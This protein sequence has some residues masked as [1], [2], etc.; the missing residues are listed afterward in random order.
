MFVIPIGRDDA[1]IR[2]HAWVSYAIMALNVIVF[3]VLGV[4]ERSAERE[5][6]RRLHETYAYQVEHP[7]LR[8]PRNLEQL[9][10][11]HALARISD[12]RGD[13]GYVAASR[14]RKE[15]D[16]LDRMALETMR[17]HENHPR[18]KLSF[19]PARGGVLT[20]FTSMFLHAGLL[21]LLG[22]LLF[23]FVSGPFVEDVFGRPL[24]AFLYL[25]GGIAAALLY[26]SQHPGSMVRAMGA[27]GAIAAVMGAYLVR[28]ATSKIEFLFIP[29]WWRPMFNFRLWL[30]AFVVLP[31]WFGEQ[32][33]A[34]T[35]ESE[36]GGV[37]FSAHVGGF[38]FG[39]V[40]GGI[41]RL[42]KF[43]E[44][45]VNPKVVSQTTWAIDDRLVTAMEARKF[46]NI[47][48]AQKALDLLMRDQK[49]PTDAFVVAMDI[50]LE[51][52]DLARYDAAAA[53]LLARHV[54][55][56]DQELAME[57]IREVTTD[58]DAPIPKFLARAAPIVERSGDR[59]WALA[60]YERLYDSDPVSAAAVGSLV[61]IGT[62][63]RLNGDRNGAREALMKARAHPACTP[64]WAPS[65]EAKLSQLG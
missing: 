36:G 24:F 50:A 27:S 40:V 64:E 20:M 57:L 34:M 2:R 7:Y 45:F 47:E 6:D 5:F 22:N 33:L 14:M 17:A 3:V 43:E 62:L 23:F 37:G 60:L 13:Y 51:E 12:L 55:A 61:K 42:T 29:L 49:A 39:L 10:A 1:E 21:H 19:I 48:G 16:I 25:A 8:T 46:G 65:I 59:E 41:V 30:P 56:K 44:R 28:F 18:T 31:L 52:N 35:Q 63:L 32:L 53:R 58:R 15:Q 54:E 38:V 11:P 26:A 4:V 9:L